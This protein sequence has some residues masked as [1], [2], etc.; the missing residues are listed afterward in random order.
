ML[1]SPSVGALT[2]L[3]AITSPEAVNLNGEVRIEATN[4]T[5]Q[6]LMTICNS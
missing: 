3:W 4:G 2:S 5:D 6:V 1:Y